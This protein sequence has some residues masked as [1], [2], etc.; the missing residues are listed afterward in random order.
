M[1]ANKNYKFLFCPG[2]QLIESGLLL[3]ESRI[4]DVK[5][6][7]T[8]KNIAGEK[9]IYYNPIWIGDEPGTYFDVTD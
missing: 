9:T 1:T 5:F 6:Y 7:Q 2:Q 3:G 4:G 8:T